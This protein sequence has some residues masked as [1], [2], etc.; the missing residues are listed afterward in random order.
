MVL[1]DALLGDLDVRRIAAVLAPKLT[2]ADHLDRLTRDDPLDWFLLY[3]SATT[4]LGAPG[5]GSYVAANAALEGLARRRNADGRPTLAVAWGPIADA[6]V[7][8]VKEDAREALSRRL[9][10][11]P[12]AAAQALD[13]LPAL[14]A[15]G[16][17]TVALARVNWR[18][19]RRYMPILASPS[20]SDFAAAMADS[21]GGDLREEL[22]GLAPAAAKERVAS[23]LVE[24][25]GRILQLAPEKIDRAR[26]LSALGMD[27]LMAVELRMALE[28]RLGIDLPLLSLSEGTTIAAVALL[29][30][31]A[32][33]IAGGDTA[34]QSTFARYETDDD[35][36]LAMAA[37]DGARPGAA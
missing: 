24:E 30:V 8:A 11:T 19:A 7:L 27:S 21:G 32:L 12:M 22:D 10:A 14:W 16:L 29:V 26:P 28:T 1:D 13:A 18:G 33:G 25:I 4:M 35:M 34:T 9:A 17:D 15:S 37:A 20:F 31:R 3:S 6:G 23:L 2:G 36:V 5:Q